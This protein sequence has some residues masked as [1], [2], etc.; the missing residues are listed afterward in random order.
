M[1]MPDAKMG[2]GGVY[3]TQA[4]KVQRL[5]LANTFPILP[6]KV[7]VTAY[8]FIFKLRGEPLKICPKNLT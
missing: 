2:S 3:L 6:V 5:I 4:G 7:E 8:F 1:P